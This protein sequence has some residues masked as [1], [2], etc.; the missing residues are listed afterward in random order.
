M[1][2][3]KDWDVVETR[4]SI[5][6]AAYDVARSGLVE[7]WQGVWRALRPR[8]AVDQLLVVFENPLCRVDI[9]QRCYRARNPLIGG[10]EQPDDV[11]IIRRMSAVQGDRRMQLPEDR[12]ARASGPMPT[13]ILALLAGGNELTALE[14]AERLGKDRNN[15][16][17]VVRGML[18][19]GTLQVTRYIAS[20]HR[21]RGA[22]VF[23][24]MEKPV[25]HSGIPEP[26][27]S[28]PP[29]DPVLT[30]AIDAIVR[31]R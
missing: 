25:V 27:A 4:E 11:P 17:V 12:K 24:C 5:R 16:L 31:L 23:A 19:A 30:G 21:G 9:D 26:S 28:W 15:V 29:A 8:F 2:D 20:E 18:A 7:G 3:P 13:L 22:R 14:L 1:K 10:S 6:L